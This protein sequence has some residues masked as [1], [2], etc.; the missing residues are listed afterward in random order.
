MQTKSVSKNLAEANL[1]SFAV[2]STWHGLRNGVKDSFVLVSKDGDG[3][4]LENSRGCSQTRKEDIFFSPPTKFKNCRDGT[5]TQT[6]TSVEGNIWP[7]KIGKTQSWSLT[8]ETTS[9]GTWNTSRHCEVESAERVSVPAGEFDT[10]KVV[11]NEPRGT[12]NWYYSPAA[13]SPVLFTRY[14]KKKKSWRIWEL[15]SGPASQ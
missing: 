10:Y 1:P 4:T 13:K 8:V 11:C 6:I 9:G 15:V 7:L 2:G 5:G 14:R 12:S 3:V